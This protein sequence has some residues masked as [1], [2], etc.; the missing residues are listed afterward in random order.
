[1]V[2]TSSL[3]AL[4]ASLTWMT[5]AGFGQTPEPELQCIDQQQSQHRVSST[6]R[7][8]E[9]ALPYIGTLN[10]ETGGNGG[11]TVKGWD[12]TDVLVRA[13]IQTTARF[14]WEAES[15]SAQ[16]SISAMAGQVMASGPR[17]QN[18]RNW[19]VSYEILTP[20]ATNLNLQTLNGGIAIANAN[21]QIR[22][23]TANG[24]V[25]LSGTGGDVQGKTSNGGLSI[26]LTGERWEGE[27]LNIQTS[28][29]GI[30]FDAPEGYSAHLEAST[31]MGA[32]STNLP[33]QVSGCKG[34]AC[35]VSVDLGSGGALVRAV[36]SLGSIKIYTSSETAETN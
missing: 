11:I 9:L 3:S 20:S 8:Q 26:V 13:L 27:Q 21:G 2:Y 24:G 33:I 16:V 10:V 12:R 18:G 19:S 34:F 23:T 25:S 15:L 14:P 22:F 7:V 5:A 35:T 17:Q 1:M 30:K 29:G 32:L 6:C 36:T 31:H 4:I 28:N